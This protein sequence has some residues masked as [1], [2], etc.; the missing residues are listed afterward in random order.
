MQLMYGIS[1][2]TTVSVGG[3]TTSAT[4]ENTNSQPN[5]LFIIA[6]DQDAR[7]L[8][9]Y[10]DKECDTPVIDRLA[11]EGITFTTAHHMGAWSGAVCTPSRTM[12][13][14]GRN[15]WRTQGLPTRMKR[16]DYK[17]EPE[18]S[19]ASLTPDDPAFNSMPAVFKR[20]GYETFR[21]CKWGNSYDGANQLFQR[22]FDKTCRF[23]DDENGS[24]WHADHVIDYLQDR[25]GQSDKKPFLIYL[26]FSHP[27][28]ARHGKSE[29]LKKYGAVDP[30]PPSEV[31]PKAPKLPA[32]YLPKQPFF[33]GHPKLRDEYRVPGVMDR[34]DEATVRNEK[35]KEFAC[36]ENLDTQ[37]GRVL[38]KLKETGELENTYIFFTSDHGIAVG[39]HA[40]MG[41]QNLYEH[42]WQVPFIAKGPGLKAGKKVKGNIY[43]MD[44]LPTL[45]ELAGINVPETVNGQSFKGVLNGEQEQIRDVMYGVYCG[46][47]KPGMRC[48]KKGDWKLI[49]YDMMDG[50]VRETQL[51]NLKENPNE[52]L[53]EHHDPKVIEL[54]GNTPGK[55][56]VNLADD[57][58]YAAKRKEMEAL[59]LEEMEKVNDPYRLWDQPQKK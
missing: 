42:S 34:R 35:G 41:K 59:L 11:N 46:G 40:F 57:P 17:H 20:A 14:T 38:K 49:K 6:D 52:L 23:A 56:Q 32:N 16:N 29:L 53:K 28:D 37:I 21:T 44:V 4:T 45:C 58:K 5:I 19:Y 31:N 2:L 30:G 55:N 18:K 8:G 25:I 47:T 9:V 7:T 13:M 39:R 24:K 50:E 12:I 33:H 36:I 48:V 1:I 51:F 22:R 54:T 15:V 10:G 26:G 3:C 43:L 27:H